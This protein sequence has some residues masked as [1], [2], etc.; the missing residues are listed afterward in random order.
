MVAQQLEATQAGHGS[1]IALQGEPGMGKTRLLD[2]LESLSRWHKIRVLRG[3]AKEQQSNAYAPLE[4]ALQSQ[5]VLLELATPLMRET[6][7]PL[8][9]EEANS[10]NSSS[11]AVGAALERWL[12][13]LERPV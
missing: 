8:L 11:S 7:K 6:L 13:K 2:E 10:N 5:P 1:I 4:Q 3:T 9:T 12:G